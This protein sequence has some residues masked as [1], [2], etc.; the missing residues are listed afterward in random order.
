MQWRQGL[1]SLL[2]GTVLLKASVELILPL[3]GDLVGTVIAVLPKTSSRLR[4]ARSPSAEETR[5][6]ERRLHDIVSSITTKIVI[7]MLP[8]F[9]AEQSTALECS[10]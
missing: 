2:A 5:P 7:C 1:A 10:L 4:R 9:A 6:L 8:G 3:M